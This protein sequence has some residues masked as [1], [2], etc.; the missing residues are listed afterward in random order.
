MGQRTEARGAVRAEALRSLDPARDGGRLGLQI[1]A[2]PTGGAAAPRAEPGAREGAR[3]AAQGPASPAPAPPPLAFSRRG[4]RAPGE[5]RGW[6]AAG[7]RNGP[8][9]RSAARE[10]REPEGAGRRAG[11]RAPGVGVGV[12]K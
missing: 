6:G 10:S 5:G 1:A 11:V 12:G 7:A 9:A 2:R 8:G 3:E 4:R